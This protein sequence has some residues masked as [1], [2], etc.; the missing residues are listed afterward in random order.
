MTKINNYYDW[1]IQ[2]KIEWTKSHDK[3]MLI[4][5]LIF[6]R[7][8]KGK[9]TIKESW[10]MFYSFKIIFKKINNILSY[11]IKW[12]KLNNSL[13]VFSLNSQSDFLDVRNSIEKLYQ[14]VLT[15]EITF[16]YLITTN[17]S[18]AIS[19]IS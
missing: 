17:F 1:E 14:L 15:L 16:S 19:I 8:C 9:N 2:F 5:K 13:W 3:I 11:K 18:L 7:D 10:I 6:V 4:V 12:T